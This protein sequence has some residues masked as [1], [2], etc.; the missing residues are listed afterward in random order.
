ML[1]S[2]NSSFPR[3]RYRLRLA[4]GDD[5]C[6]FQV[7][8]EIEDAALV[9][10]LLESGDARCACV[11]SSPRSGYRRLHMAETAE[12]EIR[13]DVSDLGEAPLFTPAIVCVRQRELKLRSTRDDVHP[14]WDKQRITLR[15]G[16]DWRSGT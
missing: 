7:A 15:K 12:Q 11:V 8:H 9:A 2:G 13:W 5:R 10:R 3:G 14:I 1:E 16:L 4:P 6:S